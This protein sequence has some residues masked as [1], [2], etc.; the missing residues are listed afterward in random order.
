MLRPL[1]IYRLSGELLYSGDPRFSSTEPGLASA[2]ALAQ[3][4]ACLSS[5]PDG[6][7]FLRSSGEG[8]GGADPLAQ[9][10]LS[11]RLLRQ[12]CKILLDF[13]GSFSMEEGTDT[14]QR[15]HCQEFVVDNTPLRLLHIGSLGSEEM[16]G[17]TERIDFAYS[18]EKDDSVDLQ[19]LLARTQDSDEL[20]KMLAEAELSQHDISNSAM[21]EGVLDEVDFSA[22]KRMFNIEDWAT[23]FFQTIDLVKEETLSP[24]EEPILED[25]EVAALQKKE[26]TRRRFWAVLDQVEGLLKEE[27]FF[28]RA[29]NQYMSMAQAFIES[30]HFFPFEFKT[31]RFAKILGLACHVSHPR[32]RNLTPFVTLL[33][34]RIL[35]LDQITSATRGFTFFELTEQS[36]SSHEG[37]LFSL[38]QNLLLRKGSQK[39]SVSNNPVLDLSTAL[40]TSSQVRA[41]LLGSPDTRNDLISLGLCRTACVMEQVLV[42]CPR[43][44][45]LASFHAHA[46]PD[47]AC[48]LLSVVSRDVRSDLTSRVRSALTR[49]HHLVC[50]SVICTCPAFRFFRKFPPKSGVDWIEKFNSSLLT[51]NAKP[52]ARKESKSSSLISPEFAAMATQVGE[53]SKKETPTYMG[54]RDILLLLEDDLREAKFVEAIFKPQPGQLRKVL[55]DELRLK[56]LGDEISFLSIGCQALLNCIAFLTER[57]GPESGTAGVRRKDFVWVHKIDE[58]EN[59]KNGES[60]SD[61]EDDLE[62]FSAKENKISETVSTFDLRRF[63][64]NSVAEEEGPAEQIFTAVY[65]NI[66]TTILF[67]RTLCVDQETSSKD[68]LTILIFSV[69]RWLQYY[70]EKMQK[71]DDDISLYEHGGDKSYAEGYL[72]HY[73]IEREKWRAAAGGGATRAL[74]KVLRREAGTR[75]NKIG[76]IIS[77]KEVEKEIRDLF[78]DQQELR[79]AVQSLIKEIVLNFS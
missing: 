28:S 39:N 65:G 7:E 64:V 40:E 32:F 71:K 58:S 26:D 33:T 11:I 46:A 68:F 48:A 60:P 78:P 47:N 77:E 31:R 41:E 6:R 75:L 63:V 38:A 12:V 49:L 50:R 25:E 56:T 29:C 3:I 79:E 37:K 51:R 62:S 18:K 34:Q 14:V 19:V 10:S 9:T 52:R 70:E 35:L 61:D 53:S 23:A 72:D 59:P 42:R 55:K 44:D 8:Q 73:G 24:S 36:P 30:R 21:F 13:T 1:H 2:A 5:S 69:Y 54:P 22:Q 27:N 4:Q 66:H 57:D 45:G 17:D 16:H 74:V 67:D 43:M 76:F 20:G 15:N